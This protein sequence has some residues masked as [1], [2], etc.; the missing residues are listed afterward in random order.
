MTCKTLTPDLY[1]I[2]IQTQFSQRYLQ[3]R[4]QSDTLDEHRCKTPQQNTRK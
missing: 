3:E 4:L 1:I 2:P